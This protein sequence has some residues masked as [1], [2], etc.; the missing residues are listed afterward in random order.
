[1]LWLLLLAIAPAVYGWV[2]EIPPN[3]KLL[4]Y[5]VLKKGDK[6]GVSYQAQNGQFKVNVVVRPAA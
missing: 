4:V 3:D 1:M 5:E 6:F 2:A